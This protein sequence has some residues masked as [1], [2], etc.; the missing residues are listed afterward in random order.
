MMIHTRIKAIILLIEENLR[1]KSEMNLYFLFVS[2][3]YLYNMK[4]FLYKKNKYIFVTLFFIEKHKDFSN[5]K[6]GNVISV[7]L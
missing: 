2:L 6:I 5:F 1:D 7:I 4:F 3:K